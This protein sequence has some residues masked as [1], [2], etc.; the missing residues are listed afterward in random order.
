MIYFPTTVID[1]FYEDP[2]SIVDLANSDKITWS[3]NETGD[4]PGYR[5]QPLHVIDNDL[6]VHHMDKYFNAFWPNHVLNEQGIRYNATSF[7][8]RISPEYDAGWIHID[9]PDIHTTILYLTPGASPTSGTA[10]YS[11]KS[12]NSAIQHT[13]IKKKYYRGEITREEQE[14][15]RIQ[16]N[17]GYVENMFFGNQYNRLIGFDSYN[18]HGVKNFNTETEEERLTLITFI[19]SVSVN[20]LPSLRVK[21]LPLTRD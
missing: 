12:F 3:K 11:K 16:N 13:E 4:W 1:N 18:Y 17:E 14:P 10:L 7:F 5:S 21:S 8:Q 15:Y 2:Q 6:W 9:Y 20:D 19:H